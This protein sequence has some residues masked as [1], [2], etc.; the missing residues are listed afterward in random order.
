M[1]Q[2]AF[3]TYDFGYGS[4]IAVFLLALAT[5]ISLILVKASG[6]DKM[7]STMEGV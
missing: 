1:Y 3:Q 4:A 5:G 2:T 7:R 6:Y